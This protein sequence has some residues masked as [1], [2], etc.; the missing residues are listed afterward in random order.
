MRRTPIGSVPVEARAAI[1]DFLNLRGGDA[2]PRE[3]RLVFIIED[4]GRDVNVHA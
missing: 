3:L 2:V 4:K 1:E